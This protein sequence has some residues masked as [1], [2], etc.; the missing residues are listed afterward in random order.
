MNTPE[1][2]WV[3]MERAVREIQD[4]L[5]FAVERLDGKRFQEDNWTRPGGGFGISRV[6]QDGHVFEKAGINMSTVTGMLSSDAAQTARV[7]EGGKRDG[8][9]EVDNETPFTVSSISLVLHP[10]N[11]FAPSAHAHYRYFEHGTSWYFSGSADLTPSYLFPEDVEHFHSVHKEVCDRYDG[12]FYPR[13]K[14]ACDEYFYLPHRQE[15]R[16]VGGIFLGNLNDR[17]PETLFALTTGCAEA[18]GRAYLPLIE[19]RKDSAFS[20]G[21][22]RW[23]RMR[24]GRYVEFNLICD[25]GTAFG[26]KTGARTESILMSLP[27]VAGWEYDYQPEPDSA[28]AQMLAVLQQPREWV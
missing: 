6:M 16:G 18:F 22:K 10:H 20:E 4:T 13:F 5:T 21:Q 9:G 2:M 7:A 14:Q 28:E 26:L 8:S 24:R 3:S 27:L 19:R 15:H 17:D 11:P 23:Q 25:R 12:A 1:D